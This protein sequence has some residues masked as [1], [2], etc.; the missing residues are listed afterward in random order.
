MPNVWTGDKVTDDEFFNQFE[1]RPKETE[2][3]G[4]WDESGDVPVL[5][6]QIDSEHP[7]FARGIQVGMIWQLLFSEVPEFE[8]P[9]YASNAEMI[10]RM[11][12]TLGYEYTA[13]Y[14]GDVP[15]G[16]DADWMMV[17]FKIREDAPQR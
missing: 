9:V 5:N 11:C 12:E 6:L 17:S 14:E 15:E 2:S 10:M 3:Y 4:I 7:E 8:I 1:D 13:S 16:T